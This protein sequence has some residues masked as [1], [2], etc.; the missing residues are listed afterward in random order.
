MNRFKIVFAILMLSTLLMM[1]VS[2]QPTARLQVIHNAADPAAEMVDV[3]L[4]GALLLDDFA[5]RSATPFINAPAATPLQIGIAPAN[6]ASV[7]DTLTS[8][9]VT[10][11]DG[12]TYVAIANGV[13][14]PGSYKSNPDGKNI[15]FSLFPAAN[16]RETGTGSDVDF[17]VFHGA[18]DAP[19]VDVIARGVATL[20]DDAAYG[21]FTGYISVPPASYTLDVTPANDN[22]TVVASFQADLSGLG[23]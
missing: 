1:S 14:A 23:G 18:S 9:S 22:N 4:N 13:L 21:D 17:V 19:A 6:S 16:I 12:G 2:A 5:F 10:L 11:A 3:Y 15:Q 20:V 8:F 7:S